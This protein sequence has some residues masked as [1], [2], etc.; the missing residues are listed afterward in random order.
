MDT[1]SRSILDRYR[2]DQTRL[3]DMLWDVQNAHGYI[4][5]LQ[6]DSLAAGLKMS[7][8][9]VRETLSFYHFFRDGPF[10]QHQIYLANTTIG[11]MGPY[12]E[13]RAALEEA[14]GCSFGQVDPTGTFGLA[15]TGCIGLS[16]QEPAM[17]V[18]DCVFT[19][20]TPDRVLQ[21]VDQ[22]KQGKTATQIA[23]PDGHDPS[24][25]AYVEAIVESNIQTRGPVLL[26]EDTDHAAVLRAC[27]KR[28]PD[29]II[30]TV[31]ASGVRGRGGA[32]FPTGLKWQLG[33]DTVSEQKYVI[34]NADEGEPGTFKD[35][36]LLSH[37]P[38]DVL[39]GMAI[40]AYAI[41]ADHGILYLR[42]EYTYL[43]RYLERQIQDFGR[44][45]LLGGNILGSGFSFDIRLQM[46][47]G[48]Y[49]CGDE[50][51]LIESCEGKRGTPRV[52]PPYPIQQGYLD[53]PTA[54]N[55]VET[56]ASVAR[57]M[58]KG[59]DWYRALGTTESAGTR[60]L[61]VSGDCQRPGVYEI[62]WGTTLNQVL[63]M[64]EAQDPKAAQISGPSGQ[65]VSVTSSG[66][67]T[68]SYEDLS[69]NGSVMIFDQSRNLLN[70]V[71]EFTRFFVEESCGIC[72]PCRA[73]GVALLDKVERIQN[74]RAMQTDLDDCKQWGSLM[75][76]TSRCGL[77]TTAANPLLSSLDA[78]N[79]MY[80]ERLLNQDGPLLPSFDLDEALSAY[81][82][83]RR[84]LVGTKGQ[85]N[86]ATFPNTTNE[87]TP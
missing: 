4:P 70:V 64:V 45:G 7:T 83:A 55:N 14:A 21:I 74:G 13:V 10:G 39:L 18:D 17:L 43:K 41:G 34:A 58:E 15:D 35:R 31:T 40:A 48:A 56:L 24:S 57:I 33:H 25:R 20:L 54:V 36:I 1:E 67:R 76:A 65:M 77:G 51:A 69:C 2:S 23:N 38:R 32:G 86:S 81:P 50:T 71:E 63:D 42:A 49:V 87:E 9:D 11:R 19:R 61:S 85:P 6:V 84:V 44:E 30:A 27:L 79:Q 68:I 47:A 28:S 46:G 59:A 29:D 12:Q 5:A 60:L 22:L 16:D 8:L 52:K 3:I 80:Q 82:R 75:T 37:A 26:Q 53:K 73:G 72:V 78:F 62:E 66:E